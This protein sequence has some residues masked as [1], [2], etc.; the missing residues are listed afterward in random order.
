MY[1]ISEVLNLIFDSVGL[2]ITVRLLTS[3]L[4]PKFHFLISG[5][6]CIWLS[7]IFTV[8]EGFWFHDFFNLLEHSFYFLA[9]ILFLVS[10]KKEILVSDL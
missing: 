3:G 7:N 5:F 10:L 1:Q 4:I 9:S 2:L 8:V 6:F